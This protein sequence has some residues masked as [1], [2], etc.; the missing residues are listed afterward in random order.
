MTAPSGCVDWVASVLL[1]AW[2]RQEFEGRYR[3]ADEFRA[4][5]ID[6]DDALA[7]WRAATLPATP[8]RPELGTWFDEW[9]ADWPAADRL[10]LTRADRL[11]AALAVAVELEPRLRPLVAALGDDPTHRLPSVGL[12]A[13]LA[14]C[15]GLQPGDVRAV[16]ASD[17][18]LTW[19]D[20]VRVLPVSGRASSLDDRIVASAWLVGAGDT[21]AKDLPVQWVRPRAGGRLR[22]ASRRSPGVPSAVFGADHRQ[23]AETVAAGHGAEL[24]ALAGVPA[25]PVSVGRLARSAVLAGAPVVLRCDQVPERWVLD[26]AERAAAFGATVALSNNRRARWVPPPGWRDVVVEPLDCGARTVRWGTALTK[27]GLEASP[28][29]LEAVGVEFILG[30]G[31]IDDAATR[32]RVAARRRKV[33]RAALRRAA[34][35]TVWRDLTSVARPGLSGVVW[36]DLVVS[37]ATQR[38]LS[39]IAGALGNRA[40]VLDGWGFGGRPGGRG[41]HLLFAGPP[42]TGKTLGAAVIAGAADLELW[43]VDLARVVDKYLGETEK[44]LDRVLEAGQASGAMLLFDEADALFGRRGDVREA[45]DRWANVEVAYLLQRIEEHDGVTVLTTNLSHNLDEAFSRRMSRRVDFAVPDAGLRRRLW[46]MSV[47]GSA[48]VADD[49]ALHTVADRF[50]LAGGAIRT[51]AL[52]AAYAA[53]AEG[54]QITLGHLVRASVQELAKAGRAPTRDELADLA[55]LVTPVWGTA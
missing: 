37:P 24:A 47:P 17:G 41:Y 42:G 45:R 52:N 31:A 16:C 27:V 53:A 4:L 54:G 50:E 2:E 23:N 3:G 55:P 36:A 1:A 14:G 28:E 32:A 22:A 43:V 49:G 25:D 6:P 35:R 26:A 51:A 38:Q 5:A 18:R 15:V 8:W 19:Y 12:A 34:R 13:E 40:R 21:T 11:V 20:V 30:A 29:V 33:D 39:E 48:P 46:R 9:S 10:G 7:S 44:A